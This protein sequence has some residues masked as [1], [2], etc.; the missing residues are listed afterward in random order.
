MAP[1]RS[2]IAD[3]AVTENRGQPGQFGVKR[4]CLMSESRIVAKSH[5]S[6]SGTRAPFR[7]A[8]G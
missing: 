3:A 4:K 7:R 6:V 2:S 5:C 1:S 8:L